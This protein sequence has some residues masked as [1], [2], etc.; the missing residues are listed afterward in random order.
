MR[1]NRRVTVRIC[2]LALQCADKGKLREMFAGDPM[3]LRLVPPDEP[4][5]DTMA[6]AKR[7][8]Y[9]R[10]LLK[11]DIDVRGPRIGANARRMFIEVDGV[12]HAGGINVE[13][14]TKTNGENTRT[15]I[16]VPWDGILQA[17]RVEPEKAE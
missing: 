12:P 8:H 11:R 7:V 15:T 14:E 13:L 17:D 4:R 2:M 16:T 10:I 5:E 1:S 6:E 9:A 3:L